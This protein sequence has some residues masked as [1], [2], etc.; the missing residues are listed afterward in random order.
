[1]EQNFQRKVVKAVCVGVFLG[2]PDLCPP[3]KFTRL[4]N[5]TIY[6]AGRIDTRDG[7]V[8]IYDSGLGL[9]GRIHTFFAFV[10]DYAATLEQCFVAGSTLYINGVSVAGV[11]GLSGF[12]CTIVF[13]DPGDTAQAWAFIGDFGQIASG[14]GVG[15]G[16]IWKVSPTGQVYQWGID[17]PA[18]TLNGFAN[19]L[20][21]NIGNVP[22]VP[23]TVP[24]GTALTPSQAFWSGNVVK[25]S[26]PGQGQLFT[27]LPVT[28]AVQLYRWMYRYRT[29]EGGRSDFSELLALADVGPFIQNIGQPGAI[30]AYGI[31]GSGDQ[32]YE[33]HMVQSPDAQVKFI[34]IFRLGGTLGTWRFLGTIPN[35][36]SPVYTDNTADL[37]LASAEIA[38]FDNQRPWQSIDRSQGPNNGNPVR[39]NMPFTWGPLFAVHFGCGD[40]RRPGYLYWTKPY[41]PDSQPLAAN[42]E[43]TGSNEPLINGVLWDG[44]AFVFTN[45]RLFAIYPDFGDPN[46]FVTLE[47]AC[48]RGLL[49]PWAL[50]VGEQGIY[51][52][53]RDGIYV[54]DGGPARSITDADLYQ[55]FPHESQADMPASINGVVS[56]NLSVPQN[57]FL[58]IHNGKLYFDYLGLDGGNYTLVYDSKTGG[59]FPYAYADPVLRHFPPL[60]RGEPGSSAPAIESLYIGTVNGKLLTPSPGVQD[61]GGSFACQV[62][63][64][65]FDFEDPRSQKLW[66]DAW[67]EI[68]TTGLALTLQALFDNEQLQ[69]VLANNTY[70]SATGRTSFIQDL[71]A[72]NADR[73]GVLAR[74]MTLDMTWTQNAGASN[75]AT[76][77][78]YSWSPA[79]VP[80]P[81]DTTSRV[82]DWSEVRDSGLDGYLTGLE[83]WVD[84][85][86][87]DVPFQVQYDDVTSASSITRVV[88][89][90]HEEKITFA[91][92]VVKCRFARIVPFYSNPLSPIRWRVSQH[93]WLAM[94]EP[95]ELPDWD[96]NWVEGFPGKSVGYIT[97]IEIV[98]DTFNQ[99][100][101]VILQA[102]L[103]DPAGASIV[104]L[105]PT[106]YAGNPVIQA[107]GRLSFHLSF[108]PFRAHQLRMFTLDQVPGRLYEARWVRHEEPEVLANW[109]A[110]FEDFGTIRII[111][112]F[113]LYADTLNIQ[114]TVN[115]E[116]DGVVKFANFP[117]QQIREAKDYG[118]GLDSLTGEFCKGRTVRL[119]PIDV[120]QAFFY[121][122]KWWA[123][124]EP[125]P[126]FNWNTSYKDFGEDRIIKG[127]RI[128]TD[129]RGADKEVRVEI[130]Q[131]LWTTLT[132]NH[133]GRVARNYDLP[134]GPNQ[135]FPHG[136]T[137]RLRPVDANPGQLYSHEW[138][139]DEE[140]FQ[141]G[142]WN[143]KWTAD[144]Y[145]GAKFVQGFIVTA[146][147]LGAEKQVLVESDGP[148]NIKQVVPVNQNG[149]QG[150]AYS[151]NPP[152]IGHQLRARPTDPNQ[153]WLYDIKWVWEPA[154]E[155][156]PLWQT[157]GWAHGKPGYQH[158]RDGYIALQSTD[159]VTLRVEIDAQV[160]ELVIPSTGGMYRK[161]YVDF[162]AYKGKLF[163]YTLFSCIPFRL[164][165]KDCEIRVGYWGRPE[166][167]YAIMNPFGGQH[168]ADGAAI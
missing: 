55:L 26:A 81:D 95:Y 98:C 36:P 92:P 119:L 38:D 117:I 128:E 51:F 6:Q 16:N 66:G 112:G 133:L 116:I 61:N 17:Y 49:S 3:G 73:G 156:A 102:E 127:V 148:G 162:P 60:G 131:N 37:D 114:K 93:K 42:L 158:V 124:D 83:L 56:P 123:E 152:F 80:K 108:T 150:K 44:R 1:M 43:V 39:I 166:E 101:T 142:N 89:T 47:T 64:P 104:T 20:D 94:D 96:T 15:T 143:A 91:W 103:A 136:R 8:L 21:S 27:Q 10:D 41:F 153:S 77:R 149:R 110:T 106:G 99:P 30:V 33:L 86:G 48:G 14:S 54:T 24:Q 29:A 121:R 52:L 59:W 139:A 160:F 130:D 135:E 32:K 5:V 35:D 159:F 78:V 25:I 145:A 19:Y 13:D 144:E 138:I 11:T 71:R 2:V 120:A 22:V 40:A 107:N 70:S 164:F 97:G 45:N 105:T 90:L 58:S 141:L 82:L 50:C 88:N 167:A 74:N 4:K 155:L 118:L 75:H 72:V 87:A 168:H 154:P 113:Q 134:V 100:K 84:T 163:A 63:W 31:P 53:S 161:V 151:F 57:L 115:V 137:C 132:V 122:V 147:T 68:D 12:P 140:P 28:D 67:F 34:D 46:T 7:T 157:Q 126:I 146:D 69:V 111:K 23:A 109:D 129:T 9:A 65:S 18:L 76:P 125:A 79:A 165:K 62:R 85:A